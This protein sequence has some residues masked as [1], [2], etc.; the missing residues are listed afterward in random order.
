MKK[1][2]YDITIVYQAKK[3]SIAL[4]YL[5][6]SLTIIEDKINSYLSNLFFLR[7]IIYFKLHFKQ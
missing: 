2:T 4:K 1:G 7:Y 5:Q 6:K 3:L